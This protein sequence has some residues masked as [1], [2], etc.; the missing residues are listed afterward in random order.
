MCRLA[1]DHIRRAA[2]VRVIRLDHHSPLLKEFE[3]YMY[4]KFPAWEKNPY[5]PQLPAKHKLVLWLLK[6]KR[7]GGIRLLFKLGGSK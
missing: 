4:K 5:L 7:Y 3:Q 1:V 6:K 2:M